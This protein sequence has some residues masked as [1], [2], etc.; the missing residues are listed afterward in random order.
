MS[1]P[2][3]VMTRVFTAA[4]VWA[5]CTFL[6]HNVHITEGIIYPAGHCTRCGK[7]I[8]IGID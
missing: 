1:A 6:G 4:L 3:L 7:Y 2:L 5:R 8:R